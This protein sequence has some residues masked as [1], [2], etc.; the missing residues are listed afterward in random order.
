MIAIYQEM[1]KKTFTKLMT[2]EDKMLGAHQLMEREGIDK[3]E[4]GEMWDVLHFLLTG[5]SAEEP[6]EEDELSEAIVGEM[7]LLEGDFLGCTMADHVQEIAQRL[8]EI[9]LKEHLRMFSREECARNE[10]YPPIWN[11][12]DQELK[13]MIQEAF[14]GLRDF[15]DRMSKDNKG[16]IVSIY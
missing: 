3:Y 9:D 4:M 12:E 15:Y 8:Q 11:K 7:L 14:E 6:V 16:V 13:R 2:A 5:V 1:D 10:I